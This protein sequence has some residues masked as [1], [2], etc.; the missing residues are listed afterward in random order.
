MRERT[1]SAC[2]LHCRR[3]PVRRVAGARS[4]SLHGDLGSDHPSVHLD[5]VNVGARLL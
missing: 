3:A 2:A 1:L 4:R 5:C